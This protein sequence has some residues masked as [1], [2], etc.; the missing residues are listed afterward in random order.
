M[1]EEFRKFVTRG[2][3]VDLAVAFI[4]GL[5]FAAVVTAFVNVILSIVAAIFGSNV[6]FDQLTFS[7]N[8]TPIPYGA[9]LTAIVS[10]LIVAWALFLLVK[11]YQRVNPQKE[12]PKTTKPCDYCRTDIPIDAVRCPN[13]TSQLV[14]ATS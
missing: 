14:T 10:F 3:L 12:E 1:L 9:L 2:N 7:L 5:A 11:A 4:I 13:C 8:G 6:T